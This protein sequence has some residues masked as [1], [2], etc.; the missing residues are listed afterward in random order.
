MSK[1]K[2]KKSWSLEEARKFS[3]VYVFLSKIG[4]TWSINKFA[5]CSL[6]LWR[7]RFGGYSVALWWRIEV[8][9][10]GREA[11]W[12]STGKKHCLPRPPFL[13]PGLRLSSGPAPAQVTWPWSSP[14]SS[15]DSGKAG[16]TGVGPSLYSH[17][18]AVCP[19]FLGGSLAK[20]LL[21]NA[22]DAQDAG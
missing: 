13:H 1:L 12:D 21:A 7:L 18:G 3:C 19:V 6:L 20:N 4:F 15:L 10:P 16:C 2:K 11:A 8:S 22:G 5:F 14:V 17:I 9:F